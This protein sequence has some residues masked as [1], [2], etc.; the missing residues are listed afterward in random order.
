MKGSF[1]IILFLIISFGIINPLNAIIIDIPQKYHNH[2]KTYP[3]WQR[4]TRHWDN[5]AYK[6]YVYYDHEAIP[7][8]TYV[9]PGHYYYFGY[10]YYYNNDKGEIYQ[11]WG[12]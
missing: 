10:P 9:Y 1:W 3:Y 6:S 7:Q 5:T 4:P 12:Y 8:Y 2:Q 11:Y